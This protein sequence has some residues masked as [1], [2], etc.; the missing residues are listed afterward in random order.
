MFPP[1]FAGFALAAIAI[2]ALVPASVMAIAASNLFNRNIV[3]ELRPEI[4]PESEA[5]AS[6]IVSLVVKFGAVGFILIA[7]ATSIV[8]FQLAGGVWILQTLPAVF[9]GL[10]L[11]RLNGRAVLA[12]WAC[13]TAWGT[14]MLV[15][16][17]FG[18]STHAFTFFGHETRI[19]TGLAALAL[20][21]L[22]VALGTALAQ[23]GPPAARSLL[24]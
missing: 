6:K 14:A 16:A 15:E 2:G 7:P 1:A 13:G 5:R 22:V 24:R 21:L 9:L 20:N 3:R 17:R 11:G 23:A 10:F 12:G 4:G 18:N 19:Y 8:N